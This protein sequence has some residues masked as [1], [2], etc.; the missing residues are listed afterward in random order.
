MKFLL[1]H[2]L[3]RLPGEIWE[4]SLYTEN[5]GRPKKEADH[6]VLVGGR[7][8]PQGNLNTWLVLA[9]YNTI[10]NHLPNLKSL[11][12]LTSFSHIYCPDGL[13]TIL[14]C[15]SCVLWQLLAQGRHVEH[16]LP[17]QEWGSILQLLGSSSL[18]DQPAV[19]SSQWPPPTIAFPKS[20]VD[21]IK[22]VT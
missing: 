9:S 17:G 13:N 6:S 18:S 10:Y 22:R 12:T 4:Q 19:T 21:C 5:R 3:R 2:N 20:P 8:N 16:T 7:F 11:E 1:V 14:L 15:Q